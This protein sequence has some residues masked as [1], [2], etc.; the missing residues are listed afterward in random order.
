MTELVHIVTDESGSELWR[1]PYIWRRLLKPGQSFIREYIG[2]SVL[3]C[4]KDGSTVR[5]VVGGNTHGK[6]S[7]SSDHNDPG[8]PGK[9]EQS[10]TVREGGLEPPHG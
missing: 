6:H 5:T 7:V 4:D 10:P 2:Y 9:P 8:E 3:S 1:E